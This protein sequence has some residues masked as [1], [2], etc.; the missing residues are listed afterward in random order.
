M[1]QVPSKV[2][3]K[4]ST[5]DVI[6]ITTECQGDIDTTTKE[7][8]MKSYSALENINI[9]DVDFL[10][11]PYGKLSS[12]FENVKSYLINVETK[13]L[14]L[15]YYNDEE[16]ECMKNEEIQADLLGYRISDISQYLSEQPSES[17]STI[18]N[19]IIQT[20]LNKVMEGMS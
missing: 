3:Y 16:L 6:I 12:T 5:G 14:E 18:E 19:F 10:T 13:E 9:N 20:E 15:D 1:N 7:Q 4:I 11:I 8:D 2:Y 17:I